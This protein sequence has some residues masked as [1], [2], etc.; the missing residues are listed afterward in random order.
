M[1]TNPSANVKQL[2]PALVAVVALFAGD[3]G[4]AVSADLVIRDKVK[5]D[6]VSDRKTGLIWKRCPEGTKWT[7]NMSRPCEGKVREFKQQEAL[8]WAQDSGGGWR[9][10]SG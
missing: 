6:T 5:D 8:W 4:I 3:S 2:L 9:L 10:P 1:R 7:G